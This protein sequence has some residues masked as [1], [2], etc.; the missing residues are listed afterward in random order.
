MTMPMQYTDTNVRDFPRNPEKVK[1]EHY[2][3]NEQQTAAAE[4]VSSSTTT[5]RKPPYFDKLARQSM[6]MERLK[7]EFFDTFDRPMPRAIAEQV[8]R[9][10]RTG[11]PSAYY[12]YAMEQTILA[13]R[14]SWRYTMAIVARLQR[15]MADVDDMDFRG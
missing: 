11:T 3:D 2:N 7:K 12:S 1:N 5:V 9:D 8:L 13:P 14:P 4:P 6:A 10:L 15:T